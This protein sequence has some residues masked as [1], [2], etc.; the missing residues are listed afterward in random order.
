MSNSLNGRAPAGDVQPIW[1]T[2]VKPD[3]EPCGARAMRG[4]DFCYWHDPATETERLSGLARQERAKGSPI[5]PEVT[6]LNTV[7]DVQ[8]LLRQVAIYLATG[9]RIEPRRAT[10]LNA[11]AAQLLR[12]IEIGELQAE[13]AA[14]RAEVQ[15]LRCECETYARR[16]QEE[17]ARTARDTRCPVPDADSAEPSGLDGHGLISI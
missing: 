11:V 14:A 8:A 15:R 13:L 1:C 7:E 9:E 12:G 10:A 6:S 16:R 17:A 2:G 4:S 5:L 3:G